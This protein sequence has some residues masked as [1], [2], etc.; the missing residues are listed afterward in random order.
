MNYKILSFVFIISIC[1]MNAL[2]QQGDPKTTEL[3]SPV[4]KIVTP[5]SSP[6]DAPSDAIIL[7]G[8]KDLN[9]WVSG[10]DGK[11]P[12]LWTIAD[13]AFTVKKGTGSI[14]TKRSFLDYQ[15]HVEFLARAEA[16]CPV[17]VADRVAHHAKPPD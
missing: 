12:A 10:K 11:S 8:G 2:A 13:G 9:E 16:R 17:E 1:S 3:W 15:L 7:F 4:P 6:S 5:G 14:Q